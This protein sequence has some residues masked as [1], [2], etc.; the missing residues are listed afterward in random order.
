MIIAS[1][2]LLW[3]GHVE[4]M[5]DRRNSHGML[6]KEPFKKELLG[7]QRMSKYE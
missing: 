5:G 4:K 7:K 3:T 1:R 2:R 6:M